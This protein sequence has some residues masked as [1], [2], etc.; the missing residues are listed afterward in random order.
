MLVYHKCD[1]HVSARTEA[2]RFLIEYGAPAGVYDCSGT[3]C[4]SLMIE[5]MP[6]I[7]LEAV[8][9]F[10]QLDLAFRK[11]YYYLSYLEP[12]PNFLVEYIPEEKRERKELKERK[13]A[14]KKLLKNAGQKIIK[15]EKSYAKTPL[16][17]T[18]YFSSDYILTKSRLL[19][20]LIHSFILINTQ[21]IVQY[22][23]MDI[24]MHP[25]FQRLLYVKWNLFGK[26]GSAKMLCLNFF[27]TV[28][29]TILGI[30]IPRDHR[31]YTPFADNWWRLILEMCGVSMTIYFIFMVSAT[32]YVIF[33]NK[34]KSM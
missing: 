20:L 23:Q 29:W 8:E 6:Q 30:L 4:L 31:Y 32:M 5:K 24:I 12:D 11:H 22:D 9:Q 14:E 3:S 15:K 34:I 21:V 26:R 13:K 18:L 2:A 10:H 19:S 25:V 16:E 27:Y 1:F 28:I 7:A 33:L 17:V